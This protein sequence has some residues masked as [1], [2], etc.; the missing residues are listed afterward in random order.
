MR[1]GVSAALT[2]VVPV[3]TYFPLFHA[4]DVFW[5]VTHQAPQQL[6]N[7]LMLW[8]TVNTLIATATLG[9]LG[10]GTSTLASV[11]LWPA[12]FH[13][14]KLF[15]AAALA[16]AIV[17]FCYLLLVAVDAAFSVD[18]RFWVIA[19]KKFAPW[20]VAPYFMYLMPMTVFFV[21]QSASLH[22]FVIGGRIRRAVVRCVLILTNGFLALLA[23]QYVPL[24]FGMPLPLGEPLLTILAIQFVVLLA[25]AGIIAAVLQ[26]A[27]GSVYLAAFINALLITWAVVPGQATHFAL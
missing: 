20:H 11:G 3:L 12:G 26:R 7:G 18:F 21:V 2:A 17:G 1:P 8:V 23:I 13:A 14:G 9:I 4:A 16:G 5:P 27:T 22:Q 25:I 19:F 24:L 6:T 15:G 10:R